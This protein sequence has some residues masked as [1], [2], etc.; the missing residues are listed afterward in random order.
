MP[1][2]D[3][4]E[5]RTNLEQIKTEFKHF[6]WNEHYRAEVVA[7]NLIKRLVNICEIFLQHLEVRVIVIPAP[8][9]T[10][11]EWEEIRNYKPSK[12]PW[13]YYLL[14]ILFSWIISYSVVVCFH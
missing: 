2:L 5:Q 11:E 3:V 13:L 4:T 9:Y 7:I 12:T 6:P 14:L 1:C 8:E 10:D